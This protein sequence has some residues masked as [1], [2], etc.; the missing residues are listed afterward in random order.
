MQISPIRSYFS[1]NAKSNYLPLNFNGATSSFEKATQYIRQGDLAAIKT[2]PDVFIINK[3]LQSLLH[4][5]SKENTPT[6]SQYLIKE[7]LGLNQADEK[8]ETPT[9]L[10]KTVEMLKLFIE[11]GANINIKNKF[12]KTPIFK[13]TIQNNYELLEEAIK[14][15][16][17]VNILD[18]NKK[19]ALMYATSRNIQKILLENGASPNM[20]YPDGQSL[21]HKAIIDNNDEY[22]KLLLDYKPN[23]SIKDSK[24][25]RPL[26]YVK[27]PEVRELILKSG[28]NPN[29]DFYLQYSLLLKN[30]TA[31]EQFLRYG[32]DPNKAAPNGRTPI[33]FANSIKQIEILS[34]YKADL[35]IQDKKGNTA[36]H[37]FSLLGQKTLI[38]KITELGADETIKNNKEQLPSDLLKLWEKYNF[39][40]K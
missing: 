29:E 19:S 40:V 9:F 12:G 28:A 38:K 15:G 20:K 13:Y 2:L 24:G 6:I 36:L 1:N 16:A 3:K 14:N 31:L 34:N 39:W 18:L 30:T 25:H 33:F 37:Q 17:D 8:G 23:L 32:S 35:N 7:G 26:F 22:V 4:I 5:S 21:I 27:N 10:V 11:N